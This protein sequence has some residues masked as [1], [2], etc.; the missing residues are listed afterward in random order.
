MINH[1]D[2]FNVLKKRKSDSN[3]GTYGTLTIV[4]G[5]ALYRGA[6]ALSVKAALRCGTGI[7]R[8]AST[9]CVINS[10]SSK[11]DECIYLPLPESDSGSISFS[12]FGAIG[13][14]LKKSTA[15]QIGSGC[16]NCDD[17]S[18]LVQAVIKESECRL[19]IDADALNSIS[20]DPI[21]IL[22]N[23]SSKQNNISVLTPHVG[24]MAKLCGIEILK[25][26]NSPR[27]TALCF[28][29]ASGCVVVLKDHITHIASPDGRCCSND[30][31]GNAGLARGGSG[32]VLAGMIASFIAQ[33]Y[34]SYE[35]A[36][37]GVYLHGLAADRCAARL[38]QYGMLPGDIIDDLCAIFL[39]N[40]L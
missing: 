4:G 24:E 14:T 36:Y 3:K 13:D 31:T 2:V 16:I 18:K 6:A 29:E 27:E 19:I 1:L 38:S 15:C 33:G 12:A 8:L 40:G 32:D 17:I 10:V 28:A 5:S 20:A 21:N 7:V 9:E 11:I 39:E 25:I 26:K 23:R 30:T 34:S 35:S 37:C 22:K